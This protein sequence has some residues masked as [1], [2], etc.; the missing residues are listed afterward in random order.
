MTRTPRNP[1]RTGQAREALSNT[2]RHQGI[3]PTERQPLDPLTE[4]LAH[5]FAHRGFDLH[6]LPTQAELDA[7]QRARRSEAL[8][9]LAANAEKERQ[10][11]KQAKADIAARQKADREEFER[12]LNRTLGADTD[13]DDQEPVAEQPPHPALNSAAL[14]SRAAGHPHATVSAA[15]L[16]RREVQ[17][18]RDN[19]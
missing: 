9:V 2:L 7:A 13:E 4:G 17:A 18:Q 6:M 15:E 8:K 11:K 5:A 12:Q 1:D 10:H 3:Q 16:L 19:P 14:L